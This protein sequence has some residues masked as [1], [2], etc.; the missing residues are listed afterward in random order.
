[1]FQVYSFRRL[2]AHIVHCCPMFNLFPRGLA[3]VIR[4]RSSTTLLPVSLCPLLQ[5]DEDASEERLA[6]AKALAFLRCEISA[7][8]QL[9]QV[10]NQLATKQIG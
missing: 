10:G 5:L 7:K 3:L 4:R 2:T 6:P 8:P 9:G 1:M